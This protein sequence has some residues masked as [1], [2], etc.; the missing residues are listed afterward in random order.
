MQ[1]IFLPASGLSPCRRTNTKHLFLLILQL[2]YSRI[3]TTGPG[4]FTASSTIRFHSF[5]PLW[6][7]VFSDQPCVKISSDPSEVICAVKL[8]KMIIQISTL[9]S[10]HVQSVAAQFHITNLPEGWGQKIHMDLILLNINTNM[11]C[12]LPYRWT[13]GRNILHT[14]LKAVCNT[15]YLTLCYNM[16]RTS[17]TT[18][19]FVE[20]IKSELSSIFR[21][22]K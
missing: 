5:H 9:A 12:L 6:Q 4:L 8:K 10:M 3:C 18:C 16:G 19:W 20:L 1:V 17:F 21:M 13:E 2:K 15:L 7:T 22:L 11:Q 14:W